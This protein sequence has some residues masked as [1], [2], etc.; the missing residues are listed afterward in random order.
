MFRRPSASQVLEAHFTSKD[1]H[2]LERDSERLKETNALR[3]EVEL[4][5]QQLQKQA[6][7]LII[8]IE[9]SQIQV[10]SDFKRERRVLIW[11]AGLRSC[12]EMYY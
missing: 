1:Y 5:K 4:Q 12:L 8:L 11:L 10:Y 6:R 7:Q 2:L 9:D 3:K